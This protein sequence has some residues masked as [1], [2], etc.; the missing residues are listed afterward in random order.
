MKLTNIIAI[1]VF[2]IS[3]IVLIKMKPVYQISIDGEE[4]GYIQDKKQFEENVYKTFNNNEQENIA[5]ADFSLDTNYQ[6]KL[7]ERD[8]L[9]NEEQVLV[10]LKEKA[11]ITYFQYAICVNGEEKKTFAK[12]EEVNQVI[13]KLNQE[14]ED[15][16]ASI[17]IKQIYTKDAPVKENIEIA[18]VCDTLIAKIKEQ[19]EEEERKEKAT[20]NGVYI[21]VMP[22]QGHVTSR[23]GARESIRDHTHKGLDIAAKTGTPIKAA[24]DGT[25]IYSG[26]MGGYGNIIILD[27]GNGITTYYGHCS[28]LY[29][30]KGKKVTAGDIIAAVGSTGNSTG[31]HL[32]FEIRKD[33]VYTDPAQYLF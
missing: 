19:I 20:I 28:K 6:F 27:H 14:F 10:A 16:E 24:A 13:E 31:S 4:I 5:F 15:D 11:D 23:Y 32:H 12:E 18:S 26:T 2:I 7:V 29:K 9:V 1:G 25:V 21:A 8:T 3:A 33:G 22:V 30:T 17:S